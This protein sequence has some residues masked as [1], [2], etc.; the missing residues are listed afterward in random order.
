[1]NHWNRLAVLVLV[2]CGGYCSLVDIPK[3]V[4]HPENVNAMVGVSVKLSCFIDGFKSQAGSYNVLWIFSNA[5]G[6]NN[7]VFDEH[8]QMNND[9]DQSKCTLCNTA[10]I[11]FNPML[12]HVS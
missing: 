11:Q 8:M 1:M 6:W 4:K 3:F 7:I 2:V 10:E 9:P 5:T 12:L